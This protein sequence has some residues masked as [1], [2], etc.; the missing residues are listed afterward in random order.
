MCIVFEQMVLDMINKRVVDDVRQ[1][2]DL[3]NEDDIYF[4]LEHIRGRTYIAGISHSDYGRQ[5]LCG[6]IT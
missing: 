2:Y 5:Y 1:V 3:P 4:D 6:I